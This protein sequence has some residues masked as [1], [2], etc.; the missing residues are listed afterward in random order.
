MQ[1]GYF[2]SHP[3]QYQ[4]PMLRRLASHPQI[5]LKVFYLTDFSA[6]TYQDPGFGR[7]V[8]WDVPL[9]DGYE[10]E[11]LGTSAEGKTTTFFHPHVSGVY[12]ALR[13][14]PWTA[15]A[16]HGYAHY[17]LVEAM[18]LCVAL[19]IPV[20]F[21]SESNLMC[22]SSGPIKDAWMR[23]LIRRASGL[24]WIGSANRDYYR[25][26]GATDGQLFFVPYAV[27]ND[28]FRGRAADAAGTV[29]GLREELGLEPNR[30]IILYAGKLIPRKNPLLL[31]EAFSHLSASGGGQRP[32]LVFV[33]DGE[34]KEQLIARTA[35]HRLQ[36]DV[37]CVGFRNQSELPGYFSL[38]DLFV[39]P[40]AREPFGLVVN[41]V[42]NCGKA[43]ITTNEVGAAADLVKDGQNGFIVEAGDVNALAT[44]MQKALADPIRLRQM[45]RSSQELIAGWNYDH[46]VAG[47]M[48]SLSRAALMGARRN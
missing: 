4:A 41:E 6:K 44:A 15:V 33:G 3:I 13:S 20:L 46:C 28:F 26:Y 12:R 5:D 37:R 1:L 9:L 14:R 11:F 47:F 7:S 23:W 39:M 18:A 34:L 22:T 24:L 16:F 35:E 17:A 42:M 27:D 38:C 8:R 40:S 43:I 2:V 30:P 45:G 36:A 10:Y 29:A 32:Y 19:R 48:A 21:R 31:L 25:A